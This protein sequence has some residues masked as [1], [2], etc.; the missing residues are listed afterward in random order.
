[1]N[2]NA[3]QEVF[4][5]SWAG[6]IVVDSNEILAVMYISKGDTCDYQIQFDFPEQGF[7]KLKLGKF[8]LEKDS[9]YIDVK[10][11]R[12]K[13]YGHYD[14]ATGTIVGKW[15]QL[16]KEYPLVFEKTIRDFRL[17]RP[18]IPQ[19]PYPY[20]EE[21]VSFFNSAAKIHLSG[22]ITIPEGKGPFPAVLIVNGSGQQERDC[23]IMGHP[24]ALV[25]SDYLTRQGIATLRYDDRGTGQSEGN[26]YTS[27]TLDFATDA[28]AALMFL[29]QHPSVLKE[30]TGIIGH[31]E[32]GIIAQMIASRS[33][34]VAFIVLL[35]AP[36]ID[37]I[38][39]MVIQN[40]KMVESENMLRPEQYVELDRMTRR[41][42]NTIL[43][44]SD[45]QQASK[46]ILSFYMEYAKTLDSAQIKKM[47]LT[48]KNIRAQMITMLSPWYR[49][50]LSIKPSRFLTK[51]KCPVLAL[52][53]EKDLQVTPDENLAAITDALKLGKNTKIT[54]QKMPS[55][56]H[57]FQT[58][59]KGSFDEY[60]KI[61]E[62]ISP[63]VLQIISSWI[64]KQ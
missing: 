43:K 18:Q 20:K 19:K 27:N 62:T 61:E 54:L 51:I 28:T 52:N 32:G 57:L 63:E 48:E 1:M 33:S 2:V 40:R 4:Y 45:N 50:F 13:Y 22:T 7:E 26:P 41:V 10:K 35:A 38:D 34:Q 46:E 30:K 31:S 56:N 11:V 15:W 23:E 64:K 58:S 60:A 36:G 37:I 21:E 42:F 8:F 3:Q 47:N 59:E 12:S 17:K 6:K 24:W 55:L 9:V 39:L 49:Y 53:G 16:G 5:G 29:R 44:T 25:L 14:E